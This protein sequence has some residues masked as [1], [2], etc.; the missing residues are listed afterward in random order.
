MFKDTL[1]QVAASFPSEIECLQYLEKLRWN[2]IVTSPFKPN[3]KVYYCNSGKYKCRDSGKYFNA[4]TG[5]MF[6][7]SRI[8]LQK[9][10]MAIWLMAIEKNAITSVDMAKELGITQKSA[11]YM[12]QRIRENFQLKKTP[13]SRKKSLN[14]TVESQIDPI[15]D[16]DRLNLVDWL[17]MFKK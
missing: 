5:T 12:M 8:S 2:G 9:W 4:K 13:V 15:T 6:H 14:Q 17:N 10:F 3:S 16:N 11:W 1:S 7:H